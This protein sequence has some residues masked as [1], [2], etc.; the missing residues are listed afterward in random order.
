M[1]ARFF[2]RSSDVDAD[3]ASLVRDLILATKHQADPLSADARI[4]LDVDLSILGQS[5]E[6][7]ECYD[8]QIRQ[9]Y[10]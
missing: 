7:F 8:A 4:L 9:E 6:R 3:V 10:A 5:S 1:G 2:L